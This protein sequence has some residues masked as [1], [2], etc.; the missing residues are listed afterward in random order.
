MADEDSARIDQQICFALYSTLHAVNRAYATLLA[1]LGLTY[2]QYLVMLVLWEQDDVPV[3]AIGER[4][5]LDS[6]TLTP[7]L[8]RLEA[9]GL[10]IRARDPKDERQVRVRLTD[11]GREVRRAAKPIPAELLRAMG[12]TAE[13]AK[14]LRK[15]LRKIR[16]ALLGRRDR[17]EKDAREAKDVKEA[18]GGKGAG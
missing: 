8:K 12:R 15:E 3:K 7:L 11:R 6:G 16:N 2:P 18:K 14:P 9:A 5:F 4:V 10:V 17:P 13:E 1:P